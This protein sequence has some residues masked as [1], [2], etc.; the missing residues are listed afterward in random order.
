MKEKEPKLDLIA[1][2]LEPTPVSPESVTSLLRKYEISLRNLRSDKTLATYVPGDPE[3]EQSKIDELSAR[4]SALEDA[5]ATL[6]QT[7]QVGT[8][9]RETPPSI[10][11]P[12]RRRE[13]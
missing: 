8:I 1:D 12:A 3:E 9:S 11:L 13:F 10:R 4:V 7:A 2:T 5:L 6:G